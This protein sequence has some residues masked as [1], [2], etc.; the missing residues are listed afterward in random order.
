MQGRLPERLGWP[1]TSRD[2]KAAE[3]FALDNQYAPS[4]ECGKLGRALPSR[5]TTNYN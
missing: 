2:H 3:D 1:P 5:A 4:S